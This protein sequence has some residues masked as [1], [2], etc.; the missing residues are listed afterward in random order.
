MSKA[1]VSQSDFSLVE[2]G[3]LY[4]LWQ[5]VHLIGDMLKLCPRRVCSVV[6]LA[7]V[8]PFFLSLLQGQAWGHSVALPFLYD[9]E[10]HLRLLVAL[11]LLI[12]AEPFLHH[13]LQK[14]VGQFQI[15]G[16]IPETERTKYEDA[17][18]SA[19]RLRN[20]TTAEVLLIAFIYAVGVFYTWQAPTVLK[21][22]SWYGQPLSDGIM[23][24]SLAGWWLAVVSMPLFQFLLLRWLYRIFIWGR[25]LWQISR[26]QLKLIPL[27]PDRC[28]GLGFL[29]L[30]PRAFGLVLLAVG[31]LLA[32]MISN[33]IFF[34]GAELLD[35]KLEIMGMTGIMWILVTGPLL[36]FTAKLAALR[37]TGEREF[38]AIAHRYVH[39]FEDKWLKSEVPTKESFLGSPDIQSLADLGNSYEIVQ[40]I[41][42][43]LC[44][45][46]TA[47]QTAIVILLPVLPLVLTMI[48]LEELV[49]RLFNLVF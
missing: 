36:V 11:P 46:E 35:F 12:L 45:A 10:T 44:S 37:R 39:E 48:P 26:F 22:S 38:G 32:G 43:S 8:P 34:A 2:G 5:R 30:S 41:K 9:V 42:L 25:F 7:W 28:G 49:K 17:V 23:Q 24:R 33:R 3:P 40:T 19:M 27:H 20:S 29:A 47:L 18:S 21:I 16:L 1:S 31:C 13:R 14:A 4:L 15:R 6:V